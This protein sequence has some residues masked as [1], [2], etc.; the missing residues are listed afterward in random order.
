VPPANPIGLDAHADATLRYIRA[1]MEAASAVTVPG[2]A[3]VTIGMVGILAAVAGSTPALRQE[4]LLVWLT[5]AL[6][7]A[8]AGGLI[9]AR[10]AA[11]QGFTLFGAPLRKLLLCLA[12]A[13]FGGAIL[14]WVHLAAGN[15][16]AIPGTWLLLYGCALVSASAPTAR[17]V[18]VLGALFIL[19]GLL[20]FAAP[21]RFLNPLLGI[22]FGGLHLLFGVLIGRQASAREA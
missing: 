6:L 3:G 10:Q 16:H 8:G 9:M 4:W 2:S 20:A 17:I 15:L 21:D 18:A 13:L 19:L 12:P 1:S 22:G 5:A 11:R 7:A 14:T